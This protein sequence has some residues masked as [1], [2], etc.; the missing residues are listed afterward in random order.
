MPSISKALFIPFFML[1][2]LV[3]LVKAVLLYNAGAS[4]LLSGGL[5]AIPLIGF[6][7]FAQIFLT[8]TA[9]TSP[10]MLG[11]TIPMF[12]ALLIVG[13]GSLNQDE[14]HLSAFILAVVIF[15]CWLL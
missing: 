4:P 1:L 9:R 12:I 7:Y 2:L 6:L 15:A 3:G 8:Q 5:L 13:L 10:H 14:N 11:Y